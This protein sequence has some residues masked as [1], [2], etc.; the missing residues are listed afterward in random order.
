MGISRRAMLFLPIELMAVR[1]SQA[2][3]T[4]AENLECR[5]G[6]LHWSGGSAVAAV[7]RAGVTADKHEGDGATPAGTY[8]LVPPLPAGQNRA[9]SV[10]ATR[11]T[12]GAKR[13]LG[14]RPRRRQLQPARF[15]SLFCQRRADMA[16]GRSLRCAGCHRLQHGTGRPRRRECDFPPYSNTG[17]R[18]DC[19]VC[20]HPERGTAWAAAAV[21]SGQ[22][23]RDHR[24]RPPK[25]RKSRRLESREVDRVGGAVDDQLGHR[26]AGRRRVE[27]PP[28]AVA[29]GD[30]GA[31]DPGTGPISGRPSRVTG[32]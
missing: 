1:L 7:G 12:L 13:W 21:G 30:V 10:T 28:D 29:G 3:Q 2:A 4:E 5:D 14:R 23:D 16:G 31:L 32:R 22:S 15:P 9:P 17:F 26:L 24:L 18:S 6:R 8:P 27:D 20:C 11:E 25:W 19:G